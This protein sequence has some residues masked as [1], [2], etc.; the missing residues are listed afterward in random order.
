MPV[1][2]LLAACCWLG[3]V[4]EGP[5]Q[6]GQPQTVS[7]NI[8]E[9]PRFDPSQPLQDQLG[10]LAATQF[11]VSTPEDANVTTRQRLFFDVV[12]GQLG[13]ALELTVTPDKPGVYV[14]VGPNYSYH[15]LTVGG[16]QP[17]PPQ[18][19]Q[20]PE[21]TQNPTQA[22]LIWESKTQTADQSLLT[23]QLRD[24]TAWSRRIMLADPQQKLSNNQPDPQI[25]AL[26]SAA[27]PPRVYL[28]NQDGS[29]V[30]HFEPPNTWKDLKSLMQAKGLQP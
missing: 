8:T 12:D 7:F 9:L 20:P 27:P 22:V 1:N 14:I 30:E 3:V 26:I 28:L 23:N 29:L 13:W 24:D 15:R 25:Q 10:W 16:P 4:I 2:L 6:I 5:T 11:K 19:P 17:Q 21:P 18:P